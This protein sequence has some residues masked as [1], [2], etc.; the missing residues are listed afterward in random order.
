MAIQYDK[1]SLLTN[2]DF[3][4]SVQEIYNVPVEKAA[5][6]VSNLVEKHM[7]KISGDFFLFSSP[8]RI[9]V[10]GNHTDHNNGEVLAA[11]VSV[12]LLAVV[13]PVQSDYVEINSLGY[14]LVKVNL[15][16]LVPR[17]EERGDSAALVRGVAKGFLDRGYAIG[18]FYATTTSDVFK[19]AGMSSSAAFEV[20]ISE[21]FNVFYNDGKVSAI[22][23]AII[24]QYA[25]NTYF[26]KPSGLM[27]QSAISLG[28]ISHIDFKDPL[29][30]A[31]EKLDWP[32][33]EIAVA[34]VNC[35]GDHA[36][37]T[38][39]YASIREEMEEVAG[40]FHQNKL[41]DVEEK[42]LYA[43]ISSLKRQV[44][45]RAILRAVHFFD[46]N[47]RVRKVYHSIKN[48][49]GKDV[50]SGIIASGDSSYKLLQNCYAEGDRSQVIP[51]ALALGNRQ[52]GVKALRV[53]GGGFAGTIL[54]FVEKEHIEQFR[55]N[56]SRVFGEKNI[57][58]LKIRNSGA[59]KLN[60]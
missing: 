12:D 34:V 23:K 42:E 16:D 58:V 41:R 39:Q 17:I 5:E 13:T 44:S 22:T 52:K 30:P 59:K 48:K 38:P 3:V 54:A 53:H 55:E 11:A 51:L 31:T 33:E 6:R 60:I 46:E 15:N 35:G 19:G 9:E 29:H 28:G 14:P 57:Y 27:D 2:I 43:D 36:D 45:G 47:A 32:F 21:I 26:G 20:L 1:K 50:F 8:G 25:E 18:G 56:M 7:E 10:I 4:E 37:L 40:F 49:I 24:S